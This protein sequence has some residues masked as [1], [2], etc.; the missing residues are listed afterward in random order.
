MTY[1]ADLYRAAGEEFGTSDKLKVNLLR[2][3]WVAD[4]LDDVE[5]EWWPCIRS[6][7]WFYFEQVPRWVAEREP[8]LEGITKE[9]DFKFDR[10]R[11]DRLIVGSPE[12]CIES[13]RAFQD[14]VDMNYLIM[15]F[16][17]AAGPSHEQ[18]LECIRRFGRDV[19]PAFKAVTPGTA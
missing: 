15:S 19:I 2:D 5:R 14:A 8:F 13:I 18:E 1:W 16:R 17:V 10:H 6:E 12:D 3:G 9:D 11:I 7:H 4:S